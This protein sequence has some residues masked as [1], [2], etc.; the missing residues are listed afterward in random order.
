MFLKKILNLIKNTNN[1]NKQILLTPGPLNCSEIIKNA[2]LKDY[3]SRDTKF[4]DIISNIRN[5]ILTISNIDKSL[6][7]TILIPGSGTYGIESTITSS[8]KNDGKIAIFSNGAYGIRMTQIAS[9]NKIPYLH[10]KIDNNKIITKEHI[11]DI[12]KNNTNITHISLVHHE[13]TTGILNPIDDIVKCINNYNIVNNKNIKI[14]I[15]A[16]SSYGGIPIDFSNN[17]IDFLISSSNKCIESVPGF[18]FVIAKIKSLHEIE[19]I[20]RSLSLALYPQWKNMEDTHQFRFT[21][22]THS[23]VA[24][25]KALEIL[26]KEGGVI[27]RNRRYIQY[28]NIIRTRFNKMGFKTYLTNNYGCIITTFYYPTLNFDFN[29]FYNFLSQENIIIYPGKLSNENVFRIGNIGNI[30]LDELYNTL[31]KIEKVYNTYFK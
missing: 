7:T 2:M 23:L 8:I 31:E 19:G 21:P 10:I 18:S 3:G 26:I 24:F 16:M 28:N 22:P 12:F 30:S 6:Y 9:I 20:E 5:N 17:N 15:D 27:E 4:I 14:I 25:N 29:K 11:L 1:I 13:T